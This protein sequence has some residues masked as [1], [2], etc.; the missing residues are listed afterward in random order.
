[1]GPR[2]V[3]RSNY[4]V[5]PLRAL[6]PTRIP[7]TDDSGIQLIRYLF[8]DTK[9]CKLRLVFTCKLVACYKIATMNAQILK[10]NKA[11]IPVAWVDSE[12]AAI[13]ISKG[14]VIWTMGNAEAVLRGGIQRSTGQ[15]STIDI[16]PIIAVQGRV[17]EKAVPRI[18]NRLLFAR[19]RMTCL[20]CGSQ[21]LARD[22]SRDHVVPRSHK[23]AD[24]WENCV[25]ACRRCNHHKADRTPEQAGMELLAVPF[26]PT[27]NEYFF[28]SNK[29]V[30]ADQM[31][32]LKGGF[33]NVMSA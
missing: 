19:D 14:L 21:F 32:Y 28:L 16:P 24:C 15:R 13:T 20:Y 8:V 33:K 4:A 3:D 22:L 12:S 6:S 7:G 9:K 5:I 31:E 11:G 25:T 18:S 29:N 27:L 17:K 2:L 1:M 30:L 26:A 10:L 23:G